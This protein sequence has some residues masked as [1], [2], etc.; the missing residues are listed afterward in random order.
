[1]VESFR[2]RKPKFASQRQDFKRLP[3]EGARGGRSRN[4]RRYNFMTIVIASIT[5]WLIIIG[6]LSS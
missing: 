1:M 5:L 4:R 3:V 6:I 2:E